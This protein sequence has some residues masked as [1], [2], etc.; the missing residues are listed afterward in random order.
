MGDIIII[1]SGQDLAITNS[2]TIGS[3]INAAVPGMMV[4]NTDTDQFEGYLNRV[5][6]YNNSH[7]A[8]LSLDIASASNLGGIKVGNNLAITSDGT[9]NATS[10]SISRK[11]QRVL[12]VNP[13]PGAGDYTS[14]GQCIHDFFGYDSSTGTYPSGELNFFH[15]N[16]STYYPYPGPEARYIIL[17]SPGLYDETTYGTI[18]MPPYTTL[19]GDGMSDCVVKMNTLVAL[20]CRE[21]SVISDLTFDLSNVSSVTSTGISLPN[22]GG[23]VADNVASNVTLDNI[24][25]ITDN[26]SKPT[27]LISLSGVNN[28]N[29]NN[30][31]A[32]ITDI[33]KPSPYT[34]QTL[35]GVL[36]SGS[37]ATLT[38][39]SLTL[40]SN[41]TSKFIIDASAS[42]A[43]T[44]N[45]CDFTVAELNT[46]NLSAHYNS[47]CRIV[48]SSMD[49]SYTMLNVTGYDDSLATTTRKCYGIE[50]QSTS[51][52][53]STSIA[54]GSGL[55]F[56]HY[57]SATLFDEIVVPKS[58]RDFTLNFAVNDYIKVS[59]SVSGANDGVVRI[60]NVFN[61]TRTYTS[62]EEYSIIQIG[63]SYNFVSQSATG[64]SITLKV[65]Y[66][67][68]LYNSQITSTNETLIFT[69]TPSQ[70]NYNILVSRTN[71]LGA[72]PA[73]TSNK[74]VFNSPF[75]IWVGREASDYSSIL[76]AISSIQDASSI[77]P[78]IIHVK[79][80][81]YYEST[82]LVIPEYVTVLGESAENTKVYFDENVGYYTAQNC[83][84]MLTNNTALKNISIYITNDLD[85]TKTQLVAIGSSNLNQPLI[86]ASSLTNIAITGVMVSMSSA[87]TVATRTAIQMHKASYKLSDITI[88][89]D[90]SATS[91]YIYGIKQALGTGIFDNVSISI[92][93]AVNNVECY[94]LYS[95][96]G[97]IKGNNNQFQVNG[98]GSVNCD[99]YGV[100]VTNTVDTTPS[101][102]TIS[103]YNTVLYGG[104]VKA[105]GGVTNTAL[106]VD[107][108]STLVAMS[109]L[110]QG[111][112]TNFE[113]VIHSFMRLIGTQSITDITA[114]IITNTQL[115]DYAGRPMIA[116][117]SLY[118]GSNIGA[119]S[120]SGTK[121]M[122]IGVNTGTS[123]QLGSRNVYMGVETGQTNNT[124]N[125]NVYLGQGAGTTAVG[126]NSVII[127]SEAGGVLTSGND[128][129]LVGSQAGS[130]LGTASRVT[131]L[132]TGSASNASGITDTV[133]IGF[134]SGT[135][136]TNSTNNIIM[137]S[138]SANA[139]TSGSRNMVIGNES[140]KGLTTQSDNMIIGHT[141]ARV[142]SSGIQNTVIGNNAGQ[143]IQTGTDNTLVGFQAGRAA[144][145][146][147]PTGNKNTVVGS[148]A[149]IN[150]TSA[151]DSVVIG[152]AAA[153][154]M[155]SGARNIIV[156]SEQSGVSGSAP[157]A[158]LTTGNDNLIMG[159][160]SA[161]NMT[162]GQRNVVLGNQN[163]GALDGT[164]DTIIIGY[165]SGSNISGSAGQDGENIIIGN[166]TGQKITSGRTILIGHQAGQQATG[167][168]LVIIG[169]LAGRTISGPR[170][171]LIGNYA[172]GVS[173]NPNSNPVLGADNIMIGT[174]TG[175]QIQTGSYN[176]I[177]G[178]G[179]STDGGA[180]FAI[181]SG[182]Y[183]LL[184]GYRAGRNVTIGSQN[185]LLGSNVGSSMRESNRNLILGNEAGRNLGS[186]DTTTQSNDNLIIGNSAA[187]TCTQANKLLAIGHNA[188][189]SSIT[190]ENSTIIG[191][192]AGYQNLT[193]IENTYIGNFAGRENLQSQNTMIGTS[194][195]R[196][197]QTAE[198][199][200]Y[201]GYEVGRGD[202]TDYT[203]N[204]GDKNTAFGFQAG[205]NIT[206]GYQNVYTGYRAGESNL[207]GSKNIAMG[208]RAGQNASGSQNVFIGTSQTDAE[209]SG[210][211]AV[212]SGNFDIFIGTDTGINNT[213]GAKNIAIGYQ[214]GRDNTTGDTNIFMGE[215]AGRDNTTGFENINIGKNAGLTNTAGDNNIIIGTDTGSATG[216]NKNDVVLIG[217]YAGQHNNAN[218]SIFI[219]KN[220][221]KLNTTGEG[222][223]LIGPDAGSSTQ[224]SDKNIMIGR[225]AGTSLNIGSTDGQNIIIGDNSAAATTI[226]IQ[227][228]SIGANSLAAA[229]I[230]SDTIAIGYE[231]GK[232]IG[233]RA[234]AAGGDANRNI[235]MG[236]Q[237]TSN[238]DINSDNILIGT[239][240]A[241]HVDNP[242]T[243]EGNLL[244]G[245]LA[246]HNANFSV[247][248][249]AIGNANRLGDGGVTNIL[250][251]T[252]AGDNVGNPLPTETLT[253]TQITSNA[254][255]VRINKPVTQAYRYFKDGD[256]ILIRSSDSSYQV[257]LAS[258]KPITGDAGNSTIIFASRYPGP[259][260][261]DI[262]SSVKSIAVLQTDVGTTD[263]SKSSGNSLVGDN[264]GNQITTGSKNI[265]FGTQAMNTNRVGRYNNIVGT[266]A[267][268]NIISD[269]NT[270]LGTR[271]GYSLDIAANTVTLTATDLVFASNSNAIYSTSLANL[272]DYEYGTVIEIGNTTDNDGRYTV[273]LGVNQPTN[274]VPSYMILEGKPVYEE[275]GIPDTISP[276]AIKVNSAQFSVLNEGINGVGVKAGW[277]VYNNNNYNGIYAPTGSAFINTLRNYGG[278]F[279]II[280]SRYN[281][282][283]HYVNADVNLLN[284]GYVSTHDKL[285]SE[286]FDS[287]VSI[288]AQCIIATNITGATDFRDF[289]Y[290]NPMNM[291]FSVNKGVYTT[292]PLTEKYQLSMP[293]NTSSYVLSKAS[294]TTDLEKDNIIFSTGYKNK[295][296]FATGETSAN[297]QVFDRLEINSAVFGGSILFLNNVIIVSQISNY[298]I[299]AAEYYDI[300]AYSN[301]GSLICGSTVILIDSIEETGGFLQYNINSEY[302]LPGNYSVSSIIFKRSQVKKL[303]RSVTNDF[304]PGDIVLFNVSHE[305]GLKTE[306]GAFIVRD[307]LSPSQIDNRMIIRCDDTIPDIYYSLINTQD[308]LWGSNGSFSSS[309][310]SN[311]AGISSTS[312]SNLTY[313][314]Y[315]TT[316]YV[317][318]ELVQEP[319]KQIGGWGIFTQNTVINATGSN[320]YTCYAGNNCI[321]ASNQYEFT[322]L[323]APCYISI[324]DPTTSYYVVKE[325]KWPFNKLVIDSASGT[326]NSTN[327]TSITSRSISSRFDTS[328]L[329]N[330]ETNFVLFGINDPTQTFESAPVTRTKTHVSHNTLYSDSNA[331]TIN[332][333]DTVITIAAYDTTPNSTPGYISGY[334]K[335][336]N[337]SANVTVLY[338]N[339][340]DSIYE[341]VD[342][343][344]YT[345]TFVQG[346][347]LIINPDITDSDKY[348]IS[349]AGNVASS[350][351]NI[352]GLGSPSNTFTSASSNLNTITFSNIVSVYGETF[353]QARLS[354]NGY[355]LFES[356]TDVYQLSFS[357]SSNTAFTISNVGSNIRVWDVPVGSGVNAPGYTLIHYMVESDTVSSDQSANNNVQLKIFPGTSVFKPNR[358]ELC[359]SNGM[360]TVTDEQLVIGMDRM[361]SVLKECRYITNISGS[362]NI[363]R[364]C[365]YEGY[366]T[367][368][369]D[370]DNHV[371]KLNKTDVTYDT[372]P[373]NNISS[374]S[375]FYKIIG[376]ND[377]WI[378]SGYSQSS[379]VSNISVYQSDINNN[380]TLF[381][382]IYS[383]SFDV[384]NTSTSMAITYSDNRII[385]ANPTQTVNSLVDAGELYFYKYDGSTWQNLVQ[386]INLD[387]TS[388]G[389]TS[390]EEFGSVISLSNDKLAVGTDYGS[391][392]GR[393]YL[394]TY[395]YL[396][397]QF[398]LIT[399]II[400][401]NYTGLIG[402]LFGL[403]LKMYGSLLAVYADDTTQTI[404]NN[405]GV[406]YLFDIGTISNPTLLTTLYS[407]ES[408]SLVNRRF[409]LSAIE[410]YNTGHILIGDGSYQDPI[411]RVVVFKTTNNW[412]SYIQSNIIRKSDTTGRFGFSASIYNNNLIVSSAISPGGAEANIYL[413][414]YDGLN[415]TNEQKIWTGYTDYNFVSIGKYGYAFVTGNY[416]YFNPLSHSRG[417]DYYSDNVTSINT[418]SH[419]GGNKLVSPN[420]PSFPLNAQ[421]SIYDNY[422]A[423]N[424]YDVALGGRV[425]FYK[426]IN[427]QWVY[428]SQIVF[429]A[430]SI[431]MYHNY[432]FM[433]PANIDE[434]D[435][436]I[437]TRTAIDV[438]VLYTIFSTGGV[439]VYTDND[440]PLVAKDNQL[441]IGNVFPNGSF[442]LNKVLILNYLSLTTS[443]CTPPVQD[444]QS[445][446]GY[447]LAINETHLVV[448]DVAP[449]GAGS[450]GSGVLYIY[451]HSSYT[452]PVYTLN[453]SG[454]SITSPLYFGYLVDI[455]SS[456]T[457]IVTA[458]YSNSNNG[459]F[460][461]ISTTSSV[462]D[463]VTDING[464]GTYGQDIGKAGTVM[465]SNK[466]ALSHGTSYWL[467]YNLADL[468]APFVHNSSSEVT[469]ITSDE[470]YMAIDFGSNVYIYTDPDIQSNDEY[471]YVK[472][473]YNELPYINCYE[474]VLSNITSNLVTGSNIVS[475]LYP[476]YTS[477]FT[478]N[479]IAYDTANITI[480]KNGSIGFKN[481][482]F[483]QYLNVFGGYD[484]DRVFSMVDI[485]A[486]TL[487]V[488]Y[489]K[490][491]G[492]GLYGKVYAE[493][494]FNGGI[495]EENIKIGYENMT[496]T[497][498]GVVSL[499]SVPYNQYNSNLDLTVKSTYFSIKYDTPSSN[500]AS[501]IDLLEP[502]DILNVEGNYY[503]VLETANAGGN[504][505]VAINIADGSDDN[506][507][508]GD[509][510]IICNEFRTIPMTTKAND[511]INYNFRNARTLVGTNSDFLRFSQVRT[512]SFA[513]YTT[514]QGDI[515]VTDETYN[516]GTCS[517]NAVNA[518]SII[519]NNVVYLRETV[520][521]EYADLRASNLTTNPNKYIISIGTPTLDPGSNV[522]LQIQ[523]IQ[524]KPLGFIDVLVNNTGTS[525]NTSINWVLNSNVDA[526]L[527]NV[528]INNVANT[529]TISNI[530]PD[531]IYGGSIPFRNDGIGLVNKVTNTFDN[532]LPG[533]YIRIWDDS[534]ND[535]YLITG[536]SNS[537]TLEY[538][539]TF[540]NPSSNTNIAFTGGN[541]F[542]IDYGFT[543]NASVA[544]GVYPLISGQVISDR[545]DFNQF[546][547]ISAYNPSNTAPVS[548]YLAVH[549]LSVFNLEGQNVAWYGD[550]DY[551]YYYNNY[552]IY[553]GSFKLL[554]NSSVANS[555]NSTLDFHYSG[556]VNNRTL[557]YDI[558]DHALL[559]P[560]S[561]IE[562]HIVTNIEF[563]QFT[564]IY[565]VEFLTS[566]GNKY[567]YNSAATFTVV[568]PGQ[569]VKVT[570]STVNDGYYLTSNTISSTS[571]QIYIDQAYKDFTVAVGSVQTITLASNVIY[572]TDTAD[573][574]LSVYKPGQKLKIEKTIYND[575]ANGTGYNHIAK[576]ITPDTE[577]RTTCVYISYP[578][579]TNESGY[580][581][582]ISKCIINDEASNIVLSDV[583]TNSTLTNMS[584]SSQSNN[585][586]LF[587]D[588]QELYLSNGISQIASINVVDSPSLLDMDINVL[589]NSG[590][591]SGLLS[592]MEIVKPITFKKIG[593]PITTITTDGVVTYHYL[594][595][596]GN[597]LMLG[598]F[599]GQ[600][601]GATGLSIHN[602]YIG[603]RVGQTN[604]GSGNILLGNETGF[605]QVASDGATSYNNKF[606]VYKNNFIGVP[607]NP[608]IGGDFASNR[609]GINT[610]DPDSLLTNVLDTTTR[611]VVNGKVRAQ[612]FNTFTGTHII[613]LE[614][615]PNIYLEQGMLLSSTGK[616]KVLALID[617]VVDC[618]ICVKANDKAIFGIYAGSEFVNGVELYQCA[619]VG[620]GCILVT[621]YNGSVENGD[622]ISSGP[623]PGYGQKQDDDILHNYTI[624]KIT[625]DI[626][627]DTVTQYVMYEG[628]AYK[629]ALVACTYHSG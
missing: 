615:N 48:N 140:G 139:I 567:I 124:G 279:S 108:H 408:G 309:S 629:R 141:A 353:G 57:D 166:L 285:I 613:T 171:T 418:Y 158:S 535:T 372:S 323:V 235:I 143:N 450:Y 517:L 293:S 366:H 398:E 113:T 262:N 277:F 146:G 37:T 175:F 435:I 142:L 406:V 558:G 572:S 106:F 8:P 114:E 477:T 552:K 34:G 212:T 53:Y 569:I 618:R 461:V 149:A 22:P 607:S 200:T 243:F 394:Y 476:T 164:S 152:T 440:V 537:Q 523:N 211:G 49:M 340:Y 64:V 546:S 65:L 404:H 55:M 502:A 75:E 264:A 119:P 363:T 370:L 338:N 345:N 392:Y 36:A 378:Y 138:Q 453:A 7:W 388:Y 416:L 195:G 227:N 170:N 281:D 601:A 299:V 527:G 129:T 4:Y 288:Y 521:N 509:Y 352:S 316:N 284:S 213:T 589:V 356:N 456:N 16:S 10:S 295:I 172:A 59:G 582:K 82:T 357:A 15:S 14:I 125:D 1:K 550:Y 480:F 334:F 486:N 214:A 531:M 109:L 207:L 73:C 61:E 154:S 18:D 177:I 409:G 194:A 257:E 111:D 374:G 410:F 497:S 137:G 127:G 176:T 222:N 347:R 249:I 371:V 508:I 429:N 47:G 522:T 19:K 92:T 259:D 327:I 117:N 187:I 231:A 126:S 193:G 516:F 269:N 230:V 483:Y 395:N 289:N 81:V 322:K 67:V 2:I 44:A 72:D 380:W 115:E 266:Q 218:A 174:Y 437:Y 387:T 570:G 464:A 155:T 84:I 45:N 600:F 130:G 375:D 336:A 454:T 596:Q 460:S 526:L 549:R 267:G 479:N 592:S 96:R 131:V 419:F 603:N 9:L 85:T 604:Q 449:T 396:T 153:Q 599:T 182:N 60:V 611:M 150:M 534:H 610:I 591:S 121:N 229:G 459:A 525:G 198:R 536:K 51:S 439:K 627:W 160:N 90:I 163:A 472:E 578:T 190:T 226:G 147:T 272:G 628:K 329:A 208:S 588:G 326:L 168:D 28:T 424:S 448:S 204:T 574:D 451:S 292:S 350:W 580:Y 560:A 56:V 173:S 330:V 105:F 426:L 455:N 318:S 367:S 98:S 232:N 405:Q 317:D 360:S 308:K 83:A 244:M 515:F 331:F 351:V 258:I 565:N 481:N 220:A 609:V 339:I 598:S 447:D 263:A 238:G 365:P 199:N 167:D 52:I 413:F 88:T 494:Y 559:L 247:N 584:I 270:L 602:A 294:I 298:G 361:G 359:Y 157:A 210:I 606:A 496:N 223:I 296:Q 325:N 189:Y 265:A 280:G 608:L 110:T 343:T 555:S 593:T 506:L 320:I 79:P 104:Y 197:T 417:N 268:Y 466:F 563:I 452:V 203:L 313:R 349:N 69:G 74:L 282:G 305:Y 581:S 237:A 315:Q 89:S 27:Q 62:T 623:I 202:S 290:S 428:Q 407:D 587:R 625:E 151:S 275:L 571:S 196:Y 491:H 554:S 80:G 381:E 446:F 256:T 271:A 612:A 248:S 11:T 468:T 620:E 91:D 557:M 551:F 278:V 482:D 120:I 441:F 605:A 181:T 224:T 133:V 239:Q 346:K 63:P 385:L 20:K 444:L 136:L 50:M 364:T 507:D 493:L 225:N 162:I 217:T 566:A 430:R 383:P 304:A 58:V 538:D 540:Y 241:Q 348:V 358:I 431:Y 492:S 505:Y 473:Q 514:N 467:G 341:P 302:P 128:N 579:L 246:G 377:T 362:D 373:T 488:V 421:T 469:Y 116:L 251:G 324:D 179:N 541:V 86:S 399:R 66:A 556:G 520:P 180:G 25:F 471:I 597:N 43:I 474:A 422:M 562:S 423:I 77:R 287:N 301:T 539:P 273:E 427:N 490:D 401:S 489:D 545:I 369:F 529:I 384:S 594:D 32:N 17:V 252:A 94:G 5:N 622:Y 306:R 573:V 619:S 30:L 12:I 188:A 209:G 134:R 255:S 333:Y 112:Y 415:W 26:C 342:A 93:S 159:V 393:V 575:T 547:N 354:N 35:T 617:T 585:F 524:A 118:Y 100:Y 532:I 510:S 485:S 519:S 445:R 595:A 276:N 300:E 614:H 484:F 568:N 216:S 107:Y 518:L 29:I 561:N 102:T 462:F 337:L 242:I 191:N 420:Q 544:N 165:G 564:G 303:V 76:A 78:Y 240:V 499:S 253:K 42:S 470:Q 185:V 478:I 87:I 99:N 319:S 145:T 178:S 533:T 221:G 184:L 41:Q 463:T 616:V 487:T 390:N 233:N 260:T 621:N 310:S 39:C 54:A 583:G 312:L 512:I 376:I 626:N 400:S 132:G 234:L 457:V 101:G 586:A 433:H 513:P 548:N 68:N 386:T 206:S 183:N 391:S 328:N 201:V 576:V 70:E 148:R 307:A 438:W 344:Q 156:G 219:G 97:Y 161:S 382:E 144:V 414:T 283:L 254:L 205:K 291:F 33:A 286:T 389:A 6:L 498:I 412:D 403:N 434:V 432:L 192:D 590:L 245:S 46:S 504:Y 228:I 122:I 95:D 169:N 443:E 577:T 297:Y 314:I 511:T 543:P 368:E 500:L 624:A 135:Q 528:V 465:E 236:Y 71:L 103:P 311:T 542:R 402:D 215:S 495:Y 503:E 335:N 3:N 411:G 530:A 442:S 186:N 553:D 250:M 31:Y 261:I 397:N 332:G 13:A 425:N 436:T 321:V 123:N 501:N 23:A 458:P 40:E 379:N 355:L 38:N 274:P 21:S 475:S 24:K